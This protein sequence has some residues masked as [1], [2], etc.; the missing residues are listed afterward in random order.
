MVALF[1]ILSNFARQSSRT[2]VPTAQKQISSCKKMYFM[3]LLLKIGNRE[4]GDPP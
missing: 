2:S 4:Y 3:L 1:K